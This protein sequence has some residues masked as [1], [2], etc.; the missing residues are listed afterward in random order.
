MR[1][2][3][4]VSDVLHGPQLRVASIPQDRPYRAL[5]YTTEYVIPEVAQVSWRLRE[6][7]WREEG[8]GKMTYE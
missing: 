4:S 1:H 6:H 2:M 5:C 8:E 7:G 3:N